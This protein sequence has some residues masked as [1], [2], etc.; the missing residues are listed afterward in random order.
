MTRER[1]PLKI[2]DPW[3]FMSSRGLTGKPL[4]DPLWFALVVAPQK[5]KRTAQQLKSAGVTVEYPVDDRVRH[6]KGKKYE[7]QV[8]M[9]SRIVYGLFE[10]VPHWDVMKE[11]KIITGVFCDGVNPVAL[12]D[13][14]VRRIVGLP[15]EEDRLEQE[16]I[17]ALTPDIGEKVRLNGGL[18]DGFKVDVTRTEYGRVWYKAITEIGTME[19]SAQVDS[20]QRLGSVSV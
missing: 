2:G 4:S 20:I 17:K 13:G 16:R 18:F 12:S 19:G 7:Y 10:Y 9:I 1:K 6:H 3:P 11:R 8:P 15:L 5:E 14:T